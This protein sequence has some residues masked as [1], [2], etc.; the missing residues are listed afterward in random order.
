MKDSNFYYL[1]QLLTT[2][3][4]SIKFSMIFMYK[5]LKQIII[6]CLICNDSKTFVCRLSNGIL[7]RFCIDIVNGKYDS[8]HFRSKFDVDKS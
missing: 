3:F 2:D 4:I 8:N 6:D 7:I 5:T 1:Y